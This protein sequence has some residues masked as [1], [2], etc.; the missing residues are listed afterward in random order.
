MLLRD[1]VHDELE[2]LRVLHGCQLGR[3]YDLQVSIVYLH[4]DLPAA[5]LRLGLDELDLRHRNVPLVEV[6]LS[7][8]QRVYDVLQL[9]FHIVKRS[10]E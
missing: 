9:P 5:V 2:E 6:F 10:A 4:N 3:G 8:V 7:E 1:A